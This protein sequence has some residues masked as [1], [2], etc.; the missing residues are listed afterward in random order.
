MVFRFCAFYEFTR[1]FFEIDLTRSFKAKYFPRK[2]HRNEVPGEELMFGKTFRTCR[3]R[4]DTNIGLKT[5]KKMWRFQLAFGSLVTPTSQPIKKSPNFHS[6]GRHSKSGMFWSSIALIGFCT[7]RNQDNCVAQLVRFEII[8]EIPQ[9]QT[10]LTG[11]SAK[12]FISHI[13][14]KKLITKNVGNKKK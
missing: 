13:N 2:I 6:D 3:W 10:V 1:K 11:L 5:T 7:E 14:R 9:F 4:M 8:L 12:N